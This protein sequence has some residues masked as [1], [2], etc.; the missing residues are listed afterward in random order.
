MTHKNF[1]DLIEN[2][3]ENKFI[4]EQDILNFWAIKEK[5]PY[6]DFVTTDIHEYAAGRMLKIFEKTTYPIK[7]INPVKNLYSDQN[8]VKLLYPFASKDELRTNMQGINFCDKIV[9]T[10]AHKLAILPN[11]TEKQGFYFINRIAKLMTTEDLILDND[12]KFPQWKN[13]IPAQGEKTKVNFDSLYSRLYWWKSIKLH[14]AMVMP[15]V[16]LNLD[17]SEFLLNGLFL[18]DV[19]KLFLQT[20]N[21]TGTIEYTE[22]TRIIVFESNEIKALLMP[23]INDTTLPYPDMTNFI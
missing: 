21:K 14:K 22:T 11:K 6:K 17:G 13:V 7:K 9:A 1:F 5:T 3:K 2:L 10:D 12:I 18:M 16:R 4:A 19:L 20:G 15:F 8:L 23:V